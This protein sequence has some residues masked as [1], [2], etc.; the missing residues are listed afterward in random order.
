MAES[1]VKVP[2]TAGGG[3]FLAFSF[4]GKHSYDDFGIYRVSDGNRYNDNLV[5]TLNDKTAETP[6]GDGLYYFNTHY[7]QKDFQISFAFDYITE[8]KLREM[9]QWLNGKE[10]G[11]L[12]FEEA[13]YKIYSVK[14]TG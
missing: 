14:V 2:S 1:I 3:S 4:K 7:R 5:P 12:W 9:R 13:P 6:N 10:M 8:E 11:D